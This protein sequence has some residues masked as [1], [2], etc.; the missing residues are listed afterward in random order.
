MGKFEI[1]TSNFEKQRPKFEEGTPEMES[2]GGKAESELV[3][4]E[5]GVT[6]NESVSIALQKAIEEA[7]LNIINIGID[8]GYWT[9]E[10]IKIDVPNCDD[11]GCIGIR[12]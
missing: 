5:G 11:D 1:E 7:V 8:S 3:E 4:V 12:G 9:Y 6:E 10:Q 2:G